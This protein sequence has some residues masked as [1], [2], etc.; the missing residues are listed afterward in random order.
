MFAKLQVIRHNLT[1]MFFSHYISN[2]MFILALILETLNFTIPQQICGD[3][4]A[5]VQFFLSITV[6]DNF[7]KNAYVMLMCWNLTDITT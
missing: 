5:Y 1:F 6:I 3:E 7:I 4:I 2:I